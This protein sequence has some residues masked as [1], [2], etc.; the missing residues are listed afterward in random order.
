MPWTPPRWLRK[1]HVV[2]A[3]PIPAPWR[4]MSPAERL[5]LAFELMSF[6]LDRLHAQARADN[7]TVAQLLHRY[8]EAAMR[9]R[10]RG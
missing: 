1:L 4:A 8:D 9:L 6:G 10:A 2:A 5:G 7:C 3:E